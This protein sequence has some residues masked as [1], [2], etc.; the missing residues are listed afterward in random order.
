MS[1]GSFCTT[2]CIPESLHG[3]VNAQPDGSSQRLSQQGMKYVGSN[4]ES[5]SACFASVLMEA[6]WRFLIWSLESWEL[7]SCSLDRSG[8]KNSDVY[9]EQTSDVH[10]GRRPDGRL[11]ARW[12]PGQTSEGAGS[13]TGSATTWLQLMWAVWEDALFLLALNFLWILFIFKCS[14]WS[15]NSLYTLF[16]INKM[17]PQAESRDQDHQFRISVLG[18]RKPICLFTSGLPSLKN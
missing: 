15:K 10:E 2:K 6:G 8:V 1:N 17:H 18:K 4:D 3:V 16:G 5:F 7:P 13:Q 14:N 11:K 9:R 12:R